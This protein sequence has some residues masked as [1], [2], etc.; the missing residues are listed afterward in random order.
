MGTGRGLRSRCRLP[1]LAHNSTSSVMGCAKAVATAVCGG[2]GIA[3]FSSSGRPKPLSSPLVAHSS[4]VIRHVSHSICFC[5]S[6]S[7]CSNSFSDFFLAMKS[8]N[9][10]SIF[11]TRA[12]NCRSSWSARVAAASAWAFNSVHTEANRDSKRR[13]N[14]LRLFSEIPPVFDAA[15]AFCSAWSSAASSLTLLAKLPPP[16]ILPALRLIGVIAGL[17]AKLACPELAMPFGLL[18]PICDEGTSAAS[19]APMLAGSSATSPTS[20]PKSSRCICRRE[21]TSEVN[22]STRAS[23]RVMRGSAAPTPPVPPSHS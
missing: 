19:A 14:S 17:A 4:H 21:D 20:S 2:V 6:L 1:L 12:A 7:F 22:A 11:P 3:A 15:T 16:V 5:W 18:P 10:C 13:S 23:K 8:A 9:I